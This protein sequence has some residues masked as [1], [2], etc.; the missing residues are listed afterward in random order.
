MKGF[1]RMAEA[2]Q[3]D[4][5][6]LSGKL[7]DYLP[8][9][10]RIVNKTEEEPLWDH[11][12][13]EYH[14]L[15]YDNMI[16]PRIKYLVLH[17]NRPIAAL[18]YN[19]A[20][21]T[22]GVRENH[23]CWDPEQKRSLL[24]YVVNNNRFLILPWVRIKNLASHLLSRTLKM[25]RQDWGKLFGITPSLVETFVDQERY[26]GTCYQAANWLFL[27]ETRG[28]S[29]V[30]KAFVYHG[31][32]K[33]VYLYVLDK[34]FIPDI[35][36]TSRHHSLNK[37][38][39][40]VP[41]MLLHKPDWSPTLLTDA[42]ITEESVSS[43]GTLLDEYLGVFEGCYARS[44]QRIHGECY[45]KGL[46]SDL[47]RKSVEPIAIRYEG[48]H[49]VRGMQNFSKD[50]L[51]DDE[52]MQNLYQRR[53]SSLF[54][55]QDGMINVDGCDMPKKGKDSAGVARQYCGSLGKTENCQ[56]GVFAGYASHKGYGLIDRAL[57]IP[58]K[59]FG[60][61]YAE[62]WQKCGI[63]EELEFKTKIQMASAMIQKA[64]DSGL[65]PAR[66][67]GADSFFG[68]NQEFLDAIPPGLSY[69]ADVHA[70][71]LV[72]TKMSVVTTPEYSGRG[73]KDLKPKASE[74]PLSVT[75]IANDGQYPW[76]K[77]ILAEG[78]KGP[79]IAD[80]KCL[81]VVE[82]RD[83]LPGNSIW[84]YIRRHEDGQIKFSLSNAQANTPLEQLHKVATMRWPIEQCF[85]ECKSYL[86]MDHIESRSWNSWNRHMLFVMMAHLF[87]QELRIRFKK[88]CRYS[89]CL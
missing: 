43:L 53:F 82:C 81:R 87:V 39:A 18:S 32:R 76:S 83:G 74:S 4:E 86:G 12:V 8:L 77:V 80:V 73:R 51:W 15:G 20:A 35:Q 67:L 6:P 16:G 31:N 41:N 7:H 29:K 46:M 33:G 19:R 49:A 5:R 11:M 21:L 24:K 65:F 48:Q 10:I 38:S 56:A 50:G 59:W 17:E 22:I 3:L 40:R 45:I 9:C 68:N 30:G 89:L 28:F 47:D 2:Y 1:N 36:R 85:E 63:P 44:E 42:G 34:Q 23:I 72:F 55:D 75:A 26:R 79:I 69:F 62:R 25:L 60:E 70:T 88:N 57:Y 52:E 78:A 27:G 14:Y 71:K 13:R 84:L 58:E 54:S 61:E 37:V 66:W 64:V